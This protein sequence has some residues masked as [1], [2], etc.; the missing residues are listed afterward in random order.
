MRVIGRSFYGA[1]VW[2]SSRMAPATG[3]LGHTGYES[4]LQ[5][6]ATGFSKSGSREVTVTVPR[7]G[8]GKAPW[9]QVLIFSPAQ[10]FSR[11]G[12]QP[13]E[14][15]SHAGGGGSRYRWR[16]VRRC[17]NDAKEFGSS[18]ESGL[19]LR[20]AMNR[21]DTASASCPVSSLRTR[22]SLGVNFKD[23]T[24]HSWL[25]CQGWPAGHTMARI[26]SQN[27]K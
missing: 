15:R 13:Q 20:C 4:R 16:A 18:P 3:W 1:Q 9:G 6:P 26:R 21:R 27:F 24:L 25:T 10:Q 23:L 22:I 2:P 17:V 5:Q 8:G 19:L 12:S 14:Q 7:I 11:W